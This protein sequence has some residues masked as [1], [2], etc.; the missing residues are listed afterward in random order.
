MAND[1]NP[2]VPIVLPGPD[3]IAMGLPADLAIRRARTRERAD[4]ARR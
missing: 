1:A 3:V 2:D 4:P